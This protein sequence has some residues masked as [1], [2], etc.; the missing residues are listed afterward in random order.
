MFAD[1]TVVRLGDIAVQ[2]RRLTLAELHA[3]RSDFSEGR[4][5]FGDEAM[6]LVKAHCKI[7]GEEFDP[8]ELSLPQMRK[9]LTELVG[10][11]EGSPISDFIGLLS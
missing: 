7:E 4:D 6:K 5:A 9:L 11:P 3:A 8:G 1:H 2:V 10:V